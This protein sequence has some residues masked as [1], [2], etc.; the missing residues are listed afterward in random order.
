VFRSHFF[1]PLTQS[2]V[3]DILIKRPFSRYEEFALQLLIKMSQKNVT[4]D[5]FFQGDQIGQI[6]AH[7]VIVY[8]SIFLR[9]KVAYIF[10]YFG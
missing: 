7:W 10:G 9:N 8:L 5:D 3:D 4:K 2:A 6:F 1:Q